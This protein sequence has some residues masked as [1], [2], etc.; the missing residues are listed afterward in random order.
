MLW[1]EGTVTCKWYCFQSQKSLHLKEG[2]FV[3]TALNILTYFMHQKKKKKGINLSRNMWTPPHSWL[4][5]CSSLLSSLLKPRLF[6]THNWHLDYVWFVLLCA[7]EQSAYHLKRSV[8]YRSFYPCTKQYC[9]LLWLSLSA[10][11][12]SFILI[13]ALL[14]FWAKSINTSTLL[15]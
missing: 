7:Q 13:K 10:L 6:S 12:A 14:P 8:S 11:S 2:S 5:L 3:N 9:H 4:H 1:Y 15:R